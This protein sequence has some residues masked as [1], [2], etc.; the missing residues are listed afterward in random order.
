MNEEA[1][2]RKAEQRGLIQHEYPGHEEKVEKLATYLA[3]LYGLDHATALTLE[4]ARHLLHNPMLAIAA[5]CEA[6]KP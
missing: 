6:W 2:R 5:I 1:K 3:Y 4:Q